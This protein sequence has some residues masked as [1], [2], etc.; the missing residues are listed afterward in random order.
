MILILQRGEVTHHQQRLFRFLCISRKYQHIFIC[1]YIIN[2][3]EA[4]R[5]IVQLIKRGISPVQVHQSLHIILHVRV[6][7]VFQQI[8]LQTLLLGPLGELSHILSHKE[9]LFAGMR[10]HESIGSAQIRKLR[11]SVAG[12]LSDHGTFSVHHLIMGKRQNKVLAVRIDHAEGQFPMMRT[13]EDRVVSHI[14][15][16]VIHP[17]HVPFVIKSQAI[18][19]HVSGHHR[20]G[21]GFLGDHN[22]PRL[23][24]LNHTIQMLKQ[25][26]GLQILMTAVDIRHPLP[27]VFPVIQIQHGSHRINPDSVGM[28]FVNPEERI[29]NQK[30]LDF[31][32][33]IIINQSAPVGMRSLS[34]IRMLI[35]ACPVEV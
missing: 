18:L 7:F 19:L 30:V 26:H 16:K 34:G 31:R 33:L 3:G 23:F 17:A 5:I 27:F 9:Q 21:G 32:P 35:Q 13:P 1:G 20:P 10:H 6:I 12:H 28:E 25:F 29:R 11:L 8:P 14:A 2:P 4:F 22:S 15:D 24:P